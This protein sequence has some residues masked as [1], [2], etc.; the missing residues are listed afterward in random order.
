MPPQGG[1]IDDKAED[2]P[3]EYDPAYSIPPK[4]GGLTGGLGLGYLAYKSNWV[5]NIVGYGA[6][7]GGIAAGIGGIVGYLAGSAIIGGLMKILKAGDKPEKK[8]EPKP[9]PPRGGPGMRFG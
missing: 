4:L 6:L 9:G 7:G 8:E 1:S 3:I 5:R 2:A